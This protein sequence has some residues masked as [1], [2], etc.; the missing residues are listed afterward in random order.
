MLTMSV[1]GEILAV[2]LIM[3]GAGISLLSAIG[4]LRFTDVYTITCGFQKHRVRSS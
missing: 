4:V 2:G 1:I 3:L